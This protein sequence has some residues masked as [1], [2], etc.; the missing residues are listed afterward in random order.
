MTDLV[1]VV[2]DILGSG[3]PGLIEKHDFIKRVVAN[4]ED[5]F[6]QTLAQGLDM[7]GAL[8]NELKEAKATEVPGAEVFKLYDTYGFPWELTE[9][10]AGES[11]PY[12]R[13]GR[14]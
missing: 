1:D 6:N 9:E 11:R 5:R 4:E 12:H 8:I 13:Y 14:F 3:V 7:L 2:I 10:I